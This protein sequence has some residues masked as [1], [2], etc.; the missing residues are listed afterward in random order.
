MSNR[1]FLPILILALSASACISSRT[2]ETLVE[3][4]V[5]GAVTA[6]PACPVVQDPPDPACADRPVPGAKLKILDELGE[7]VGDVVADSNGGFTLNLPAGRYT[8]AP[9]PM[10]GLMGTAPPQGFEAGP[11]LTIDLVF[12]YDTGIR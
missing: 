2:E 5:T 4:P 12:L 11:G 6:G 10:E 1:V 8:L 3:Y 7:P 9:Q